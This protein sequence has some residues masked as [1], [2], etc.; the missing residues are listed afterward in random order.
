MGMTWNDDATRAEVESPDALTPG[1]V[2][3]PCFNA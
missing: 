1:L 3:T 2:V